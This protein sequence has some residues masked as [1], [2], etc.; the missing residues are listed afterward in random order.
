MMFSLP[1][2]S[3]KRGDIKGSG[4]W[5]LGGRGRLIDWCWGC[6][7]SS[8]IKS[9]SHTLFPSFFFFLLSLLLC[10]GYSEYIQE[11]HSP[12]SSRL[13]Y[14]HDKKS[15]FTIKMFCTH[16]HYWA[17]FHFFFSSVQSF[18]CVQFF[19]TPWTTAHQASLSITNSRSPLKPMPL[20]Q[21]CHPTISSC[22]VPFSSC[23]QS[24][25]A[26]GFFKWVRTSH[27]QAKVMEVQLQQNQ[28]FQWTPR[29]DLL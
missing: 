24:L 27:Q 3:T 23:L 20:S 13:K 15:N 9:S 2:P 28:S 6:Q 19:V 16:F 18:S 29:T 17:T 7:I 10:F 21:Q 26:S 25:P 1:V 22:V 8:G 12:I 11:L 14:I 4:F 5:R